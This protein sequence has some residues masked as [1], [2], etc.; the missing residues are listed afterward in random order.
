MLLFAVRSIRGNH[1]NLGVPSA[2]GLSNRLRAVFLKAPVPSGCT[3]T[4]SGV[5]RKRFN[6]YGFATDLLH[7]QLFEDGL[8]HAAL[9][10]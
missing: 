3:F 2:A 5:E 6:L 8:T 7:L 9:G 4:E 1:M 10:P